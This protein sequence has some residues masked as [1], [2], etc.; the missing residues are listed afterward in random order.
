MYEYIAVSLLNREPLKALKRSI[1]AFW[2]L[3]G[4]NGSPFLPPPDSTSQLYQTSL[5]FIGK[6]PALLTWRYQ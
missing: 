4:Q 2:L 1:P 6:S 5:L 3:S